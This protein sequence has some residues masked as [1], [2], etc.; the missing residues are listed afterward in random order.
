MF[1]GRIDFSD[2]LDVNQSEKENQTSFLSSIVT[3]FYILFTFE[4]L[5]CFCDSYSA[6]NMHFS[7][8]DTEGKIA[9]HK[10]KLHYTKS[11]VSRGLFKFTEEILNG[12][13]HFLCSARVNYVFLPAIFVIDL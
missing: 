7:Y 10:S 9:F 3:F 6:F 13:L 1:F 12:K 8:G 2:P 11:A 4:L 5:Y